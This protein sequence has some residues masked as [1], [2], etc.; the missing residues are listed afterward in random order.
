MQQAPLALGAAVVT[1]G[2]NLP[3][4]FIIYVRGPKFLFDEDL[5]EYLAAAMRHTLLLAEEN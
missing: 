1:P 4:R 3:N 2:F 5:P